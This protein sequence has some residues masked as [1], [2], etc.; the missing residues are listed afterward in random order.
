MPDVPVGSSAHETH[1]LL[2]VPILVVSVWYSSIFSICRKSF[3]SS[4]KLNA[5]DKGGENSL[6]SAAPNLLQ[7]TLYVTTV[8]K[9]YPRTLAR[10][11]V[12]RPTVET[13]SVRPIRLL[14]WLSAN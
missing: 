12:S 10:C 1:K 9:S 11:P 7:V 8:S 5:L 13:I 2:N 6:E 14:Q 4:M 3:I